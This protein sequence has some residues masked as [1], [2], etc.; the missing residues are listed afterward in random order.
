MVQIGFAP[1]VM[2]SVD[3]GICRKKTDILKVHT[4]YS[5]YICWHS[6]IN[7]YYRVFVFVGVLKT[8]FHY[9]SFLLL[10]KFDCID[11]LS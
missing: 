3:V 7:L 10:Q 4:I 5:M 9:L 1:N 8:L 2:D 11:L 6:Y